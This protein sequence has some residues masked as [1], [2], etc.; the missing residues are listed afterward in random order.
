L[1]KKKTRRYLPGLIV[2][3]ILVLVIVLFARIPQQTNFII[4]GLDEGNRPDSIIVGSINTSQESINLLSIP[5]DTFVT[6]APDR[7]S[8]MQ[9]H[10]SVAPAN[11]QMRI[12]AVNVFGGPEHGIGFT[13]RQIEDLLD[14]SIPYYMVV[15]LDAFRIIVD[16][17]GGVEF[18]V[19]FRMSYTDP[20][21]DLFIDLQP[22]MQL[23][24]G[25]QAEWLVRYRTSADGANPWYTDLNRAQTQQEFIRAFANK[26]STE[27][28][29]F[30]NILMMIP[31]WRDHLRTNVNTVTVVRYSLH[32]QRFRNYEVR[33]HM[34]VTGNQNIGGASFVVVDT[35]ASRDIIES[36]FG[37]S[38]ENREDSRGIPI[39]VLNGGGRTGLAAE[40]SD[41]L[42]NEGFLVSEIGTY[43]GARVEYTRIY[44]NRSGVGEDIRAL[45]PNSRIIVDA[46]AFN[47]EIV[48][49]IGTGS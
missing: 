31:I 2:C 18:D 19:P 29:L 39:M 43:E 17:I 22:G 33:P 41:F 27:Q 7:L 25:R 10:M 34:L 20:Y 11:G 32:L 28:N 1:N 5:R 21:Q 36:V 45:Y 42:T 48:I 49:V 4:L 9:Q 8:V 23:L 13:V 6:V 35:D 30:Q 12:N 44:V 38:R 24:N 3:F 15:E 40:A 14:I 16:R 26:M 46:N 37:S 47:A